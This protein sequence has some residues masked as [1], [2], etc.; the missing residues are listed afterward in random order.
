MEGK[1]NCIYRWWRLLYVPL[2]G[3]LDARKLIK[4]R[5]LGRIKSKASK[6]MQSLFYIHEQYNAFAAWLSSLGFMYSITKKGS[7]QLIRKSWEFSSLRVHK[8]FLHFVIS[9]IAYSLV[10]SRNIDSSQQVYALRKHS[11]IIYVLLLHTVENVCIFI[12]VTIW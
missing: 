6:Q 8:G 11:S 10:K 5:V 12:H 3:I 9:C 1:R 7:N 2:L 4:N